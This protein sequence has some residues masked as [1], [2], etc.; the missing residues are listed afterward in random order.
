MTLKF[1]VNAR[2]KLCI[3]AVSLSLLIVVPASSEAQT[4]EDPFVTTWRTTTENESIA[5]QVGGATGTYIIDWGDGTVSAGVSGDQTHAYSTPGDHTVG[6]S[7]NF[8]RIHMDGEPSNASKIV[9]I[10]QWGDI[11]WESMGHA[12]SEATNMGYRATDAPDLS[13]VT[14]MSYMFAGARSFNSNLSSWDVS[15]VT[16]MSYMF[17]KARSF[18]GDISSWDVSSVT[19]MSYMFANARSFDGDISSWDV[20]SVTDMAWMFTKTS[21]SDGYISSWNV[22]SVTDMSGMFYDTFYFDGDLSSWDV[23]S[24]TDMYGM[25]GS[26]SSF[27]GD[28]SSWDVSSVT[29]MYGMFVDASSF[30]GDISSWN[31][32]SVTDMHDMFGSASSFDGDLSS[33]NVSS[34][35]DMYGMFVDAS[36]F[37]GDISSW[38]VS[39]VTDMS[40]MFYNAQAFNQPLDSWDVSSVTDMTDIFFNSNSFVQNLGSWYVALNDTTISDINET[41]TIS[42]QNSFLDG[43]NPTYAV[44]GTNFVIINGSLAVNYA[45]IPLDGTHSVT[46]ISTGSFGVDNVRTVEITT[47]AVHANNLPDISSFIT[48]WQTDAAGESIT[49]PVGGATGTYTVDWGD[50][51]TS[52]NVTGDQTHVYEDA[53]TYVVSISGDFT[54]I[55]LNEYPSNADKLVSIE[56]WGDIRWESMKSAF[57]GASNMV[58][59]ATDVPVLSDVTTMR[60]MF[61]EAPSFDGDLT[62]WDVSS[63]TDMLLM[64]ARTSSFNGDLSSWDVSSV[65]DM[66]EMFYDAQAFNRPLNSW[67]VSSVTDMSEM[68]YNARA[69]NQPLN[70]WNVSSVTDMSEM[71]YNAR[72]FNQPLDSWNVSSVTDMAWMF[73]SASSFNG[74][75]SSWNASSVTNMYG[76]FTGA[77]SF[78]GDLSFWNVSSVTNMSEMF[79]NA[80][81][82]NQPLDFWNVSSVTDMSIMFAEASSFNGDLS[83]WNVSSV[84]NMSEMFYNAR[85]FNQPLNSWNVSSVTDM[86]IMFAEASSF[87]G[88][89][90]SWNVSSVTNMS[91]MFYNARAFNQPLNSWNVSS[92]TDMRGMF[93][94]ARAFNQPLDSWNVSSVTDMAWMFARTSSFNGDI[95][96]WDVSS[97]TD[98]RGMFFNSNAF[99]QNLGSWYVVLN[100]TTISD[101]NEMLT[102]SAQNSFLDGQN[103]T[104]A[105][106]DTRF[107]ISNGA[108]AV[109]Y[110]QIPSAGTYNVTITSTGSFGVGNAR[111]VEITTNAVHINRLPA[112][113]I[114]PDQSVEAGTT[115]T[116]TGNA[117]DADGDSLT[118]SWHQTSGLPVVDLLGANTTSPTFTAPAVTSYTRLI[119]EVIA[120]DGSERSTDTVE[121]T[122]RDMP[123]ISYFIT[124]WRTDA[125]GEPITIPVGG[126]TGTYTVD[127]GDK[128]LSVNVTGDQTHVY[129]DAGTYVVRISGDFTRIYLND[130]PSNA[131][132]LVSIEQWG[133]IRWE[134][135]KSA[136]HGASNMVYR[137]TDVPILSDVTTMRH[138]FSYIGFFDGDL[139]GWDVSRVTDMSAMF[140]GA[141]YFEGD[142]SSWNVSSVTNMNSMFFNTFS[143]DG[144][145]S[146]WNVSSV[147]DMAWMFARTFS[148][149]GDISSWN[150]SSVTNMNSM[151][152]NTFSFDSDI[153]SWDVSSVTDM[154]EM[155]HD[156]R[157]F[158]Q[159]LGNWYVVLNDTAISD[160]NKTLTISAQNSF[161]DG[162]NPTYAVGDTRFVIS[163]GDL[164]VNSAQIPLDGTHNVTIISTGSFGVDNV[165]T[166]EITTDVV[167]PNRPPTVETGPDQSIVE[168]TTVTLAGNATDTDG[169]SMTYS[170]RQTSGLP[171]VDL[172]GANTTSPTFMAPA[173]TSD[174]RFIFEVIVDDGSGRSTDTVE[175]TIRDMPEISYFI[176]TWQTDAAGESITI[177][178]G[179]ATGTYTVD[180]GDK[181]TSVNVTGD[182]THVYE[183]AGTYVV[184]ISGDFTRIYLNEYPSNAGKLVSIEQWGDI[185][186]E[187]MKSAFHGASNMVYRATDVP[188]LSDVTTM[189][190]MFY[191]AQSFDGDLSGWDVSRVTD[192][193]GTF[194]GASSFDGDLSPWNVSRV[195]EMIGTF[196]GASSFDADISGWDVSRVTDM[197]SMFSGA[198]S[199]DAD[200]S[201]WDVS[202]VTEMTAMFSGTSSFD[203][204][205]S[206]WDVSRVTD[207][208]GM[209]SGASSFDADISGWDVSSV[210]EMTAM[211]RAADSFDADISGW[212]VSRVTGMAIMFMDASSFDADISGWDVSRVT[213]MANMFRGASS[214]NEDLSGWD[215]SRVT[216]MSDMF[217]GA[218]SF[219]ADISG[220]DVS[221]VTDMYAMF[222]GANSFNAGISGWDVSRVTDMYTMFNQANAFDQNLGKWYIVPDDMVIEGGNATETV[223]IIAAQNSFLR[224]QSPVYG[225]GS[226]G[227]STSFEMDGASLRLKAVS[228]RLTGD[229]YTVNVTSSGGFGTN[230]FRILEVYVKVSGILPATGT[231]INQTPFTEPTVPPGAPQNLWADSTDTTVT[232]TW[233]SPDDDSITG[234][235]ILS[236]TPA[237]Q[238]QLSALVNDTG[239]PG[240]SYVI[241]DLDPDTVYVFR[242]IAINVHG[243]SNNSNFV[244]LSTDEAST[245]TDEASTTT[246]APDAPQNLWADSTDTTVTLTWDSPDDDSITGYKILSR[247]PAT[248]SQLSALVNDTGA[249]GTSYVIEDLDPDTVYVF[250]VIA[251]NV[252]G[253]SNNSNFVRLSTL[254]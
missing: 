49:I 140:S 234:Y 181:N 212:D 24:V 190:H 227:D 247:T 200:I 36:S 27:D 252:H 254:S 65:T 81:A 46:I 166:V 87:N 66:S 67:D 210:T 224:D 242:V 16:D 151:F 120:D 96:F 32:S 199:F 86:S 116:L 78:N 19:D 69:F 148:F 94:S 85:A 220:W 153:S 44:G 83:S 167:Q 60:Y 184:S 221:R 241:E 125:A 131:G 21:F 59:R 18:D 143:F 26:A 147:T 5:I 176:T 124:T 178:V 97:V 126:A 245:T 82:F 195:T 128:S 6:I 20:S 189:R 243:E 134:S 149:D 37:D 110:D 244:R 205:I 194:W 48:T 17:A 228:D 159:N 188:V 232:L 223:G 135:M 103:P 54:R 156:A 203:A 43:H 160:I 13:G 3:L 61:Y 208:F 207:M 174:T 214:F 77:S 15:S 141:S 107:V 80:R 70:S 104:Y 112:I 201:G 34:V 35:T 41:L 47:D 74:D 108:L 186:W 177:P 154:S 22:S 38:N 193:S 152:F 23:S 12:F 158:N 105:V 50:K 89:L 213:D 133:D 95:S 40:E 253:E 157:A 102:I 129:E 150:V 4:N 56:Q 101:I 225:I 132:K 14:D 215:V 117:T 202:R 75:L 211:F 187:S 84:T 183:D 11:R 169:D 122:I 229:S 171:V 111:T 250:R 137:A 204:D 136:F 76:M 25:F 249:P 127:W 31:V 164:A 55:Y 2:M 170:W 175:V 235:K 51:N 155:F 165:R 7:G 218:D 79:Y 168:G 217:S 239:A 216:D 191:D 146:S 106:A 28:L 72:A 30:D 9:S 226:G 1:G 162:H 144:D 182:Q 113:E 33:W 172:L 139:S 58:Y 10:D 90:S 98:M 63:V 73:A 92:V 88:D 163:N 52:V 142:I 29:D 185:R 222:N 121:V 230:N 236:R 114:G 91:E 246:D 115:V 45:Q 161:L 173:V 109:N 180:W 192:M 219:N 198:S 130:H 118:Y 99:A 233:D 209:F 251:I 197:S 119:F 42:A 68:F 231:D 71:F 138:M 238:S 237:T 123:N 64:F 53:G 57:H 206:G 248:Q 145:I 39:S 179:G 100:D 93:N 196:W 240:T 8:T 62:G